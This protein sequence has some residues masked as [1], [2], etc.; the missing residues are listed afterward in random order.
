VQFLRSAIKKRNKRDGIKTETVRE[1]IGIYGE[2]KE[3]K[4]KKLRQHNHVKIMDTFL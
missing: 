2:L 4:T 3:L 1:E